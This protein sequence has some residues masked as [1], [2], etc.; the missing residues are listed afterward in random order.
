MRTHPD[1]QGG[2]TLTRPE[3]EIV[4]LFLLLLIEG[5]DTAHAAQYALTALPHPDPEFAAWL[6][7]GVLAAD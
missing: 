6:G 4:D 2:V 1:P 5:E 3:A 7:S